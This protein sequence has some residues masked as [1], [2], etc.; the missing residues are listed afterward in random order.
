MTTAADVPQNAP[1]SPVAPPTNAAAKTPTVFVPPKP[2]HPMLLPVPHK[3]S[4]LRALRLGPTAN[5]PPTVCDLTQPALQ[6]P[7]PVALGDNPLL[8]PIGEVLIRAIPDCETLG[9]CLGKTGET[10]INDW[11]ESA[12]TAAV[13][14]ATSTKKTVAAQ[15]GDPDPQPHGRCCE[16]SYLLVWGL[17]PE[18]QAEVGRTLILR[19]LGVLD[20]LELFYSLCEND[21]ELA[22]VAAKRAACVARSPTVFEDLVKVLLVCKTG[23]RKAA[24]HCQNLCNS[25]GYRTLL[26]RLTF[27]LPQ[28]IVLG[29]DTLLRPEMG[30]GSLAKTV[31]ALAERCALGQPSPET[32]LRTGPSLMQAFLRGP[33]T[34]LDDLLGEE[35]Q[36]QQRIRDLLLALPGFGVAEVPIMMR[37]LG[38]HDTPEVSAQALRAFAKRF[39]RRKVGKTAETLDQI[40]RRMEKRLAG[41]LVYRGLAQSLLMFPSEPSE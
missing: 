24:T 11:K 1:A 28:Q 33:G 37:L 30:L 18:T 5:L 9:F 20:E 31:L 41:F 13:S 29:G 17:H 23:R 34:D 35:I 16:S 4:M 25:F 3:Y 14:V 8:R 27:P 39:P 21:P 40:H 7:L 36:W 19:V 12:Q 10:N 26:N 15:T 32:L 38:L 22:W 6:L 2:T